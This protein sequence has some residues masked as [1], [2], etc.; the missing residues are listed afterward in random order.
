MENSPGMQRK[1]F[2]PLCQGIDRVV[3][4][5]GRP[6]Y[7]Q[8]E[9][10]SLTMEMIKTLKPGWVEQDGLCEKCWRF[11]VDLG[12]AL[13]FLRSTD[14]PMEADKKTSPIAGLEP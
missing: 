4:I 1:R 10:R 6:L 5:P 9:L 8:D 13:N 2:C 11:Y 3:E 7:E 12:R 14:S